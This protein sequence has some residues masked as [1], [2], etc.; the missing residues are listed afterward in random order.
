MC[1]EK[2]FNYIKLFTETYKNSKNKF[3]RESK[4]LHIQFENAVLPMQNNDFLA[5][6]LQQLPLGFSPQSHV[7]VG[8][9]CDFDAV[10]SLFNDELLSEKQKSECKEIL[11]FWSK[12]NTNTKIFNEYDDD[13]LNLLEHFKPFDA[14]AIAFPL[15][16]IGG[17][18]MDPEK[19][20][21]AGIPGLIDKISSRKEENSEF[22]T[23]VI[24][25]LYTIQN[26]CLRYKKEAEQNAEKASSESEREQ[27]LKIADN[28]KVIAYEKPRTFWQAM[29]LSYLYMMLSGT[30][31]YGRMDIYLGEYL[32]KDL[33]S[34][35]ITE[36]FALRLLT[37]LW[38]LII[39][40]HAVYDSR[41]ILGGKDRPNI[42]AADTFALLAIQVAINVKNVAP[43]LTLRCY[44]GM[45]NQVYDKAIEAIGAG[46]TFPIL[47]NDDLNIPCVASAFRIDLETAKS[48]V[49][50]G[51]GEFVIYNQSIGTPSGA[52]NFLHGLNSVIFES[53]E[54]LLVNSSDFDSFYNAFLNKM[55]KII[56]CLA[57][58]EKL[59]YDICG[60]QAAFLLYSILYDDCLMRAKPLFD[61]G[62]KYL[63]GTLETYGNIN[64]SDS[65]TAIKLM[66]FDKK[67][68]TAQQLSDALQNNFAGY[69][70]IQN[71]LLS[72][73]KYGNDNDVADS[74]A[75]KFHEDICKIISNCAEKVGLHSYL[76][77]I[78]NNSMNTT[79]GLGTGASADGRKAHQYMANAN[80]PMNGMDQNGITAMLNSLVKLKVDIHAGSV[81]NM[82]FDKEMFTTMLD[83]TKGLLQAYFDNGGSQAM[84]TVLNRGDLEEAVMHPEKHKN[85]I[86]RV[87][88]FSA[89]FVELP[90]VVQQELLT[91]TLY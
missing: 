19:L 85:L 77:V 4:C 40:R 26:I 43:Q 55:E 58:Q 56:F 87:G 90:A 74:M 42:E 48:Y 83:K 68:I 81:Q 79:F 16:R 78:I 30:I 1:Q 89:R 64:T 61:G 44:K 34:E 59:E 20:L 75:V 2:T 76:P 70:L 54:N 60:S 47:Y 31:N 32:Q 28:F 39:S 67:R 13:T 84:V 18:Q 73:P 52:I 9:Y 71:E 5:G 21:T 12:E 17:A 66:V 45:N 29:Q 69:E 38:E 33:E 53:Q 3:E 24:N 63:G 14:S 46:T 91:R 35:E 23:A 88:G 15:Y 22:F 25:I 36:D 62:I 41:I 51:C 11:S 82:R 6:R 65:L 80:N 7:G 49:P 50:Y 86:V 37:N 8:Y 72:V 10:K 57:K 27:Y